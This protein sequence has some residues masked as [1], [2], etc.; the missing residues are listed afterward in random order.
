M[1]TSFILPTVAFANLSAL[2]CTPSIDAAI[3]AGIDFDVATGGVIY[4]EPGF[5]S[6]PATAAKDYNVT[7]NG[8]TF[9]I[10]TTYASQ[11]NAARNRNIQALTPLSTDFM[12]W[13]GRD[14]PGAVEA[15]VTLSG[16]EFNTDYELS[17]YHYNH[18]AFQNNHFLYLGASATTGTLLGTFMATGNPNAPATW[19]PNVNY[20]LNSGSAGEIVVTMQ[21][22]IYL[23]AG[24]EES[25]L[26]FNGMSV[27]LIPEPSSAALLGLGGLA[28]M[29]RRRA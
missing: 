1:K 18:G 20:T 25:R 6:L 4:T 17:F 24:V 7:H 22:E 9:D 21:A 27:T 14:Q 15:T 23:N 13:F 28:L 29:R 16:L 19:V 26:T 10:K 12:Q 8:I 2:I 5:L 11:G 3:T